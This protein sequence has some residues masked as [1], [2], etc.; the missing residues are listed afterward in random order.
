MSVILAIDPGTHESGFCYYN[1][2]SVLYCGVQS[3]E[4]MVHAISEEGFDTL[5]IEHIESYGMAVGKEVFATCVWVG[6]FM[7][8][9][10]RPDDVLLVP[11][12]AVK[13]HLCNSA[14]AKDA[15]VRQAILDK[16]GGKEKAVGKKAAPGPLYEVKSHA[17]AALGVALTV[18]EN[19]MLPGALYSVRAA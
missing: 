14:R 2:G 9:W 11:R 7:Q 8:A 4:R 1:E 5:A 6:R 17:W 12:R 16:F 18:A 10:R 13:M 3:N 15:N 19:A